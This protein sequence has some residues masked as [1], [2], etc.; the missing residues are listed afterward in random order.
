[1][2]RGNIFLTLGLAGLLG[3]GCMPGRRFPEYGPRP[4]Q[5]LE[6]ISYSGETGDG[7]YIVKAEETRIDGFCRKRKVEIREKPAGLNNHFFHVTYAIGWDLSCHEMIDEGWLRT[8]SGEFPLN[9]YIKDYLWAAFGEAEM[10]T[11]MAHKK[12]QMTKKKG[13]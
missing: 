4:N 1:M 2:K 8:D 11:I 9:G 10:S 12:E 5:P 7:Q 3:S 6:T 13:Q